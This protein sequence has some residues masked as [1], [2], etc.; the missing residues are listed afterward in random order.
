[1]SWRGWL[2]LA[3]LWPWLALA[4]PR[5]Q[6]DSRLSPPGPYRVG[7]TLRLEVDLL[8]NTWFTQAPQPA[9]LQLAGALVSQP[10]GQADKLSLQ[11]DGENWFGLR[12][13]YLISPTAVGEFNIAA[14]TFKLQVGQAQAPFTVQSAPQHLNVTAAPASDGAQALLL[15]AQ[16]LR[17]SQRVTPS[18]TPLRVGDSLTRQLRVEADGAQAMLIP[19]AEFARPAGLKAYPQMPVVGAL[20]DGRGAIRGGRREDSISYIIEQPG[21]YQ[22]PAMHLQWWDSHAATLR[23][24]SVAAVSFEALAGTATPPAFDLQA[25]L[26]RLGH[27][28]RIQLSAAS[29][30][31]GAALC[32]LLGLLYLGRV[33]LSQQRRR[34]QA[35]LRRRCQ[36]WR[37]SEGY[38]WRQLRI[39]LR[40][41]ALPLPALYRWLAHTRLGPHLGALQAQLPEAAAQALEG[42]LQQRYGHAAGLIPSSALLAGL[43]SLRRRLRAQARGHKRQQGLRPLNPTPAKPD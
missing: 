21:H 6:V 10:N 14:L 42:A 41:Q 39:A 26:Q 15:S 1:M 22:L 7:S 30:W 33:W 32:L 2:A 8:S 27:G 16:Q 17:F 5:V 31:L 4:A 9:E 25:D 20:D 34:L 12:L 11:R 40:Q 23:S 24:A 3:L 28:L 19:P 38:A 13:S 37:T 29:L 18:T 36:A 43:R 35:W